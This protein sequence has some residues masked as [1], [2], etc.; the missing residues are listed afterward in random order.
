MTDVIELL[1]QI[2]L[3]VKVWKSK[4]YLNGFLEITESDYW[5]CAK[6]KKGGTI[7]EHHTN[8]PGKY[9]EDNFLHSVDG[10]K[11]FRIY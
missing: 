11:P 7:L 8:I 10:T 3:S 6:V 9:A 1:S 5:C 2:A 4:N